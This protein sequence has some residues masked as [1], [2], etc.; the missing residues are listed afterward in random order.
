ML[1]ALFISTIISF[2]VV[3]IST[4]ILRKSEFFKTH[5]LT[6]LSVISWYAL[7]NAIF[8]AAPW[9]ISTIWPK[10]IDIVGFW[11]V[12]FTIILTPILSLISEQNDQSKE[13]DNNQK[14]VF[15]L[16]MLWFLS[17]HTIAEAISIGMT[18]SFFVNI[19]VW[20]IAIDVLHEAP[21]IAFIACLYYFYTWE[22]WKTLNLVYLVW[23][24]Y[25]V[26]A[27]ITS[28]LVNSYNPWF[29][30]Y[31]KWFLLG[32]Y[33][34]FATISLFILWVSKKRGFLIT[35]FLMLFLIMFGYKL[36]IG[37]S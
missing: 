33:I 9:I 27:I 2:A 7:W 8:V 14:N 20:E 29:V 11:V 21:E 32:W 12:L 30:A 22:K 18:H 15:F 23:L 4:L 10:F 1:T 19:N 37:V 3:A 26:V 34:V 36:F 16:S 28:A 5:R 25:P 6:F 35:N 24:L 13:L 31:I 17:V